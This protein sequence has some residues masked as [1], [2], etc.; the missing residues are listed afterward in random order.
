MVP[1]WC[2]FTTLRILWKWLDCHEIWYSHSLYQHIDFYQIWLCSD[3]SSPVAGIKC[4][5]L[6]IL[7][8]TDSITFVRV[9]P[10]YPA[11]I[12]CSHYRSIT[13]FSYQEVEGMMVKLE[14]RST[15]CCFNIGC[16]KLVDIFKRDTNNG[17]FFKQTS[18]QFPAMFGNLKFL[19]VNKSGVCRNVLV[20]HL[21]WRMCSWSTIIWSWQ[22]NYIAVRLRWTW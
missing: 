9:T 10:T 21:S 17:Y 4:W 14:A 12:S 7:Q 3:F 8:T 19:N 5:Q 20:K 2:I 13:W 16:V 1:R 11:D 15:L 22:I 6:M 18:G